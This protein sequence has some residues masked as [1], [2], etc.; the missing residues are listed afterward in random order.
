MSALK[1][2]C[3]FDIT[4]TILSFHNGLTVMFNLI[5]LRSAETLTKCRLNVAIVVLN[6]REMY[7][8]KILC[9]KYK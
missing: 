4:V 2:F 1:I 9:L 6:L 3:L 5:T 7:T 8:L